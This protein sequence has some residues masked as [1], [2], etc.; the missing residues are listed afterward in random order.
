MAIVEYLSIGI[1]FTLGLLV[2]GGFFVLNRLIAPKTKQL[3]GPDGQPLGTFIAYEC[4]EIPIGDA[5]QRFSFQYYVFALV[6]VLFDVITAFLIIWSVGAKIMLRSGLITITS[7]L[8]ITLLGLGYWWKK[9]ALR[10]M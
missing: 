4:G 5:H 7:F 9:Q 1:L 2:V 10:W 6:F 3:V 8:V